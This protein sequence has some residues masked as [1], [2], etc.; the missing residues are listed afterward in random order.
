[1]HM[2]DSQPGSLIAKYLKT[3]RVHKKNTD[4]DEKRPFTPLDDCFS[5]SF[6]RKNPENS[7][8][9]GPGTG[10]AAEISAKNEYLYAN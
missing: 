9:S 2:P 7:V 8:K 1:M 5:I 3:S 4:K 6:L 10:P